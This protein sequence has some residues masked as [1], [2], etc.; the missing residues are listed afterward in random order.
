MEHLGKAHEHL[1]AAGASC[2]S[3]KKDDTGDD[4]A[5]A[6]ASA[7]LSKALDTERAEK[8][9]VVAENAALVKALGEIVPMLNRLTQRVEDIAEAPLPAQAVARV[10]GIMS[11]SK[12][13]DGRDPDNTGAPLLTAE[14]IIKALPAEERPMAAMRLAHQKP[15]DFSNRFRARA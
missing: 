10:P 6:A 8:A 11:V 7:D 1:C 12:T 9:A 5:M 4:V 13:Q 2:E 15:M 14:E 3:V